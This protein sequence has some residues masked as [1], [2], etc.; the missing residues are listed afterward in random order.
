MNFIQKRFSNTDDSILLRIFLFVC[1]PII[2]LVGLAIMLFAM[3]LSLWQRLTGS[4]GDRQKQKQQELKKEQWAYFTSVN[5]L[6]I[7]KNLAN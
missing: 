3:L 5:D 1:L 2:I 4:K 6:E 7:E